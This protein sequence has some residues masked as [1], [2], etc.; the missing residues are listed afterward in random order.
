VHVAFG[1]MLAPLRATVAAPG[2]AVTVPPVQVVAALGVA[3]TVM[4]AGNASVSAT[5]VSGTALSAVLANEIVNVDAAPGAMTAGVKLFV[6]ATAD[7]P[8]TLIA[9]VAWFMLVEP[10]FVVSESAGIVLLR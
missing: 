6:S 9:A 2:R 8:P 7:V 3:A 4:F 10:W 5:A 1:A